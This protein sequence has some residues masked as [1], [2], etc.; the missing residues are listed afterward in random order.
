MKKII[1]GKKYD[2]DTAKKVG[3]Y[4]S[5]NDLRDFHW[6]S[7]TLYQK[8]TGEFFLFG[9][10]NAASKYR[11]SCGNNT[12]SSGSHI[13]PL[14]Y[15]AA[16]KWAEEYLTAD[17]YED[18]FGE[19]TDDETAVTISVRVTAAAAETAHREAAKQGIGVGDYI[20][21]KIMS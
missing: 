20:S 18:I 8:K 12:W 17:E 7:E 2:T 13:E 6:W 11:E 9:R 16:Q 3:E 1:S 4:W 19:I 10:G 14:D 5:S 15:E 21:K